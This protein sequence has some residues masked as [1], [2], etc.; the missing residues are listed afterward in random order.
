MLTRF[1]F[2]AAL[3]SCMTAHSSTTNPTYPGSTWQSTS[4]EKAGWSTQK[5]KE[6]RDYSQS[7]HSAAVVIIEH[8]VVVDQWGAVNRKLSSY[9]V[10]KSF[11]SALYGIYA[12][13]GIVDVNQTLAQAGVDDGPD[14]LTPLERQARIVDLLR[15]RSGI[16]H[17]VDFETPAMQ[18]ARP[19]R[20]SHAPGSFWY[21]NNWDFNT[22]GSILESKTGQKLGELFYKQIAQPLTMEDFRPDDVYYITAAKSNQLLSQHPAF[23]FEVTARDMARFGLLY[24]RHGRWGEKQIVP[25]GWV[26]KSSHANEMI[27]FAGGPS[28]GYEYLWWVEYAGVHFPG[29]QLPAGTFSARGAGGHHIII[30]PSMDIVIVHRGDND[31]PSHDGPT[32]TEYA[33]KGVSMTQLAPLIQKILDA[34]IH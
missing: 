22:L 29:V 13:E 8:G 30:I 28:G 6:A 1:C 34:K 20:D 25:S 7:I 12:R 16:Y 18:A 9:S 27:Q 2:V 17:L 31:P 23:H 21:Y 15:A 19:A 33:F 5:L 3:L 32:V 26:D 4:P 10:R 24:L 14:P 11:M